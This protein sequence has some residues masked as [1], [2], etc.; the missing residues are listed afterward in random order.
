MNSI[1]IIAEDMGHHP[2]WSN[3][4]NNVTINLNT[5]DVQGLS[6]KDLMLAFFVVRFIFLHIYINYINKL[7][8]I[9]HI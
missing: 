9:Y 4:Y 3:V 1:A 7:F 6:I 2:D 5:H 8:F